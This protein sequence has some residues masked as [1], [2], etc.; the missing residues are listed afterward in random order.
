MEKIKLQVPMDKN[1]YQKLKKRAAQLGFDSAPAYVRFWAKS[2]VTDSNNYAKRDLAKPSGQALRYLE[3]LLATAP[4][5]PTSLSGA[6][7]YVDK[8]LR[9]VKGRRYLEALL[10]EK[11]QV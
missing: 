8:E 5:E 11:P 9:R 4:E 6:L 7:A 10:K 1:V 2:A 3:L